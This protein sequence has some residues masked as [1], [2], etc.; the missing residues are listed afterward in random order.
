MILVPPPE[1]LDQ[2]SEHQN[3]IA[4]GAAYPNYLLFQFA[5]ISQQA[6]GRL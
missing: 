2:A 4:N 1:T 5:G 6:S 3:R